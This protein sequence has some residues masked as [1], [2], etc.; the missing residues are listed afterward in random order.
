LKGAVSAVETAQAKTKTIELVSKGMKIDQALAVVGRAR[1]T[2]NLWRSVDPDFAHQMDL[3]RRGAGAQ[4][5]RPLIGFEEFCSEFLG[6]RLFHHQ[7]QW[8]DLLEG[9]PPRG[10]HPAQTYEQGDPSFLLINTPPEHAKSATI[11]TN[12]VTYRIVTDPN[13]RI[14]VVSKTKNMAQQFMYSVK[15]RLT[16]PRYSKLQMAYAPPGG[17]RDDAQVWAADQVYLG[18][19]RDSGEKD[20]TLQAIGLGGQIYGARSDL[21]VVDDSVV[22]SNAAEFEKQLRWLQQEVLTRIG[23]TGR[24]LVVGTRVDNVDLYRELREPERYPSGRSPWTYLSQPAVLEFADDPKDW[25]TLWPRADVPWQGVIEQA[26]EEGLYSRWDGTHL[27]RRR[28]MLAPKT[29]SLAYMQADVSDDSIFDA[30]SVRKCINGRRQP[31]VMTGGAVGHRELGMEGLYVVAGLDPAM[32]GD[33][34]IIVMGVDRH[35]KKRYILHVKAH[36]R[37]T[38]AWIREQIKDLTEAYG[39]HEWRVEKNAFQQFLT[40]DEEINNWLAAKGVRFTE[41]HTGKNKADPSFGVAS[42]STLFDYGFIEL[43]AVHQVESCKQLVDQLITWSPETRGKTDLVMAMWFAEI[44]AREVV[45]AS[46]A[47][48]GNKNFLGNRF[49]SRRRRDQQIVVNLN[50]LAVNRG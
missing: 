42:M 30:A 44:R 4:E 23:P 15:Q 18:S 46:S 47:E 27:H 41:H 33:T 1:S 21:I 28:G 35:S 11:S 29:W 43:P 50:D 37:S 16:H 49:L 6:Q 10:L 25:V 14:I 40:L 22:L 12:Y 13:V 48:R 26:D 3:V 8:L 38:P 24:L 34:G 31:G 20:P 32:V 2:Y 19:E 45:N 7:L 9:R 17:W 36:A 5:E 39:I